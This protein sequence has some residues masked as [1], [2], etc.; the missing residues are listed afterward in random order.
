MLS[1]WPKATRGRVRTPKVSQS[2]G[3]VPCRALAKPNT[4]VVHI[5]HEVLLECDA[6]SHRF[7]APDLWQALQLTLLSLESASVWARSGGGVEAKPGNKIPTFAS[8]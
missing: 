2:D 6:T 7:I 5:S 3:L 4:R 8:E 1:T